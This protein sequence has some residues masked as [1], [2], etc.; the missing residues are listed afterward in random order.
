MFPLLSTIIWLPALGAIILLLLPQG[1]EALYRQVALTIA[2]ATFAV[3]CGLPFLV[4]GLAPQVAV[5]GPTFELVER[6]SWL[7]SWGISYLVGID[8][9][10]LWMVLLTTFVTLV[11]LFAGRNQITSQVRYFHILA[12]LLETGVLGVFLAQD[13]LLFYFF[14]EF[15]LIPMVF[16]I[17]MWG[18][19]GRAEAARTF[20]VYTFSASVLMLLAIIGL[21]VLH[22]NALLASNPS[23]T[24]TMSFAEIVT[25]LRSG[26]LTIEPNLARLLFGGFFVAFA[27]KAPIWPLHT[28]QPAAYAE[29]PLPATVLLGALM[30]K[31]GVYGL[32]RFNLTL[33]PE[34][35]RWAAPAV[36]ILAVVGILYG[37][38]CAAA[39]SDMKRLVAYSSLSHMGFIVLGIFALN[40][41]GVTGAIIQIVN[42][43][44]TTAALFLALGVLLERRGTLDLGA[45]G[46]LWKNMPNFAGVTLVFVLASIGLPGLNGFIGEY[47]IMQ[48]AFRSPDLGWAFVGFAVI[49]VIFAAAY[50]LRMFRATFM[51]ELQE[52][53]NGGLADL[54]R[55]EALALGLLL[56]PIVVIGLYPGFIFSGMQAS[57]NDL[58]SGLGA[59]V[60]GQ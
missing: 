2:A 22:R 38:L 8:G 20:F 11:T 12:L 26:Q 35:A 59:A 39:Q 42:H 34:A 51:G 40:S 4:Q 31:M 49:G 14:W 7:P 18:G 17:G 37:A 30:S 48:G 44:L 6:L 47:T 5:G 41:E 57:V 9:I 56:I 19:A 10:S 24:G 13:L 50:L 15:T 43:G 45:Y 53:V 23:Y 33:F 32:I 54:T 28:W 60:A 25:S 46:G 27:V 21:Y 55:N 58:L 1:R 16:M 3:S 52:G 36:G 29:A